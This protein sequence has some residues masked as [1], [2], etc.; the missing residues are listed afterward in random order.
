[1][2]RFSTRLKKLREH[3]RKQEEKF[4][5]VLLIQQ[6]K[7]QE[8]TLQLLNKSMEKRKPV[9][10]VRP[11]KKAEQEESDDLSEDDVVSSH[12]EYEPVSSDSESSLSLTPHQSSRSMLSEQFEN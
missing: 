10:G 9:S 2:D 4:Q 12:S 7:E 6:E 8:K 1:M 3:H 5:H 11:V